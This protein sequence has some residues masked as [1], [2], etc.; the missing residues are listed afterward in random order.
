VEWLARELADAEATVAE[1]GHVKVRLSRSGKAD[2]VVRGRVQARFSVPC[3]RTGAPAPLE[4]DA[5]L[6]LLLTPKTPSSGPK[7]KG[8]GKANAKAKLAP[9]RRRGREE[10]VSEA[11]ADRGV[12]PKSYE[13]SSSEADLDVYDGEEVVL[14]PFVRE[15]LL[16]EIPIFPLS[17]E[18]LPATD[19]APQGIAEPG[20]TP[21]DPRLQPLAA[22]RAR[23]AE[24]GG[25]GT[26]R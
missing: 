2:I 1:P 12:R 26:Q 7:G 25:G 5:E 23:L 20:E 15:A 19:P 3:G 11:P 6:T 17:P 13:F 14:D 10:D 8:K 21:V 4:V 16:L 18:A 22:I 9:R 24:K